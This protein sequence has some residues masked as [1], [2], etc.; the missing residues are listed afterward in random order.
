MSKNLLFLFAFLFSFQLFGQKI[1]V[2][3]KNF[4]IE[5]KEKKFYISKVIDSRNDTSK[6]GWRLLDKETKGSYYVLKGGT[7]NAIANYL[8][9]NLKPDSTQVPLTLNLISLAV[10]ERAKGMREG[11]AKMVVQFLKENNGTYGKVYETTAITESLSEFGKDIYTTHE[12]RIRAVLNQCLKN[13]SESKWA[14]VKPDF[15]SKLEIK[16]ESARLDTVSK[17]LAD[18]VGLF[19]NKKKEDLVLLQLEQIQFKG[20]IVPTFTLQNEKHRTLW[21]FKRHFKQLND[22]QTNRL[23]AD[24]KGKFKLS[25]LAL[26]IGAIFIGASF[27]DDSV[28]DTGLPNLGLAVPG[29]AFAMCSVPIYIKTNKLARKTVERYNLA[30]ENK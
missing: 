12:R 18:T 24:Y 3:L 26:G 17:H 16:D 15:V 20:G 27:S 8:N 6:I 19:S 2:E 11:R 28:K 5:L 10:T 25:F 23:C 1:E 30:I 4:P 9:I 21:A 29:L 22:L 14:E 7:V 13:L